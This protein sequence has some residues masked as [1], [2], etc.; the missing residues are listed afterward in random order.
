MILSN[1]EIVKCLKNGD[2]FIEDL[3]QITDPGKAPFNTSA[4]DL[5]LGNEIIIPKA[6]EMPV[7][8][9]LSSGKSITKLLSASS[10]K[11][12]ISKSQPFILKKNQFILAST[13]ERVSFPIN[14]GK[15][16][17]C[18]SA[19]VEG[20]SSIAR[21]GIIIHLTAPTIHSNFYGTITLELINLSNNNFA[22]FPGMYICQLIIEEVKGCP[23]IAPNQF[24]GQTSPIGV[25]EK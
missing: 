15:G 5:R 10:E 13:R 18:F 20:K 16:K 4:I 11:I 1:V 24:I 14:T 7:L 19:R 8:I 9:D 12:T 17:K 23:L 2:F 6:E 3:E 22:L 21:C 25:I